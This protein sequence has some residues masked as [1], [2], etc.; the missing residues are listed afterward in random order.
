MSDSPIFIE[1]KKAVVQFS[2]CFD[3]NENVFNEIIKPS[4]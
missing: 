1:N 4:N 2:A 3:K